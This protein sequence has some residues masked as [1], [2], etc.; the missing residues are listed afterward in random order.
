MEPEKTAPSVDG[1]LANE[2]GTCSAPRQLYLYI[3]LDQYIKLDNFI[4]VGK[5]E[6]AE[7]KLIYFGV[8][9]FVSPGSEAM[10]M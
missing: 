3:K 2:A 7:L 4:Y 8:S 9:A 5:G 10:W 1:F 6:D